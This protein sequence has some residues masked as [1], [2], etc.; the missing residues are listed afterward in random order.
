MKVQM[1]PH[2]KHF[3]SEESGIKRVVEAYFKHLPKF[4][5]EFVD[6]D[7]GEYDIKVG[8][9]G[10]SGADVDVAMLHGLYWTADYDA[11][12]WE[13]RANRSVIDSVRG[14][15][16]TTVPSRWVA[17][18]LRRD[19]HIDPFIIGHGIDWE[20]WQ[21]PAENEGYVL[22][23]K[24]RAADV[25]SPRPMVELARKS[26]DTNFVSTFGTDDEPE[27][28]YTTG[29][30]A[31]EA[32]K[33][34]VK[35]AGVYL[36]TTKETFGIGILE[37]M[38]AGVPVLGFRHGGNVELVKH[39]VNGYLARPGDIDDLLTGLRYC[40]EHRDVLGANG[41]DLAKM[42]T[43]ENVAEQLARVFEIA[44]SRTQEKV[45]V[46]FVIPCYNKAETITRAVESVVNQT[47][48]IDEII[49]VDDGS[50][51]DSLEVIEGLTLTYENVFAV[52]Q[53]NAGVAHARNAGIRNTRSKYVVCLD[54]DD[55][56]D[57]NFAEVCMAELE[58]D[59]TLGMAY[60][61]LKTVF[62]NGDS[63]ISRWPA[64]F[65]YNA[66]LRGKNQVPTCAMF[67][68]EAWVR[69]GGF[70]QRYAPTGAGSE[71]AAFW[72]MLG[73]LGYEGKLAVNEALFNYSAGVGHT[74]SEGYREFDWRSWY[75]WVK[76]DQHPAGSVATPK[77]FS[78]P[79]RQ[80]DEPVVSVVISVGPKHLPYLQDALDSLEAQSFRRWEVIVSYDFESV[81]HEEEIEF[82]LRSAPFAK[83]ITRN[84]GGVRG[85][86]ATRNRGAE[87]ARGLFLLFLDA[88]D[89][90]EMT[91]IEEMLQ[92]W[93]TH[94]SAI[95]SDY[96]G[97]AYVNDIEQLA[98]DLQNGL[99]EYNLRT[100]E[101]VIRYQASD[102]DCD[103]LKTGLQEEPPYLWCN[104]TTLIPKLWHDQIGGFD[105][106]MASWEDVDY[107]YRIAQLGHC[108]HRID[109]PLLTY[110]FF[111]GDRRELGL[112]MW[113]QL[114]EY[115]YSKFQGGYSV[116]C[117]GC[118]SNEPTPR[119]IASV[120]Q[121]RGLE[122]GPDDQFVE[123]RLTNGNRGEQLIVGGVTRTSYGYHADGEVFLV[124][125]ADINGQPHLFREVLPTEP[126][127]ERPIEPTPVPHRIV[128][129]DLSGDVSKM[130]DPRPIEQQLFSPRAIPNLQARTIEGWP[131]ELDTAE[132]IRNASLDELMAIPGVG[133]TTAQRIREWAKSRP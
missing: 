21:E 102:F 94:Q 34:V 125:R 126:L 93:Q 41:R 80:Y 128:M 32:M 88:D 12:A 27:N 115:M 8:H 19:F 53:D 89:W 103:R 112:S 121:S 29:L 36:S 23:N 56:V 109:R 17:E 67:R 105:E 50:T 14:A 57:P 24:N 5:I 43:W 132:S 83:Y 111:T 81:E 42:H 99:V 87:H 123:A 71:D 91:A 11:A 75:P 59:R 60:T 51:D 122:L 18:T 69:S 73:A 4:G 108:F 78:H 100:Q 117:S 79:V 33:K 84:P 25:C 15:L 2:L 37:A 20:D 58:A 86:G 61:K 72:T 76:D 52:A 70:R 1:L 92:A 45:S 133:M 30:L 9:A 68:R 90:L 116:S 98:P 16:V 55:W 124:H 113:R 127:S 63:Q 131:D 82:Y 77:K 120:P 107:W 85:A 95:Y 28:V 106:E 129:S 118:S 6:P 130:S 49:L 3:R 114:T 39:G 96:F 65:D 31:H 119:Q 13:W 35:S 47:I 44:H 7:S 64:E 66:Q 101:A 97:R 22:W 62:P 48:P 104:V 110:R 40:Q 46:S 54:A 74:S 10:M 26:R 38:A